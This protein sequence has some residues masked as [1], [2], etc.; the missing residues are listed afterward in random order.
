M[1]HSIE[2]SVADTCLHTGTKSISIAL[3]DATNMQVQ[4][5][6]KHSYSGDCFSQA[7]FLAR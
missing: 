6:V 4:Q 7:D 1:Q 5:Q 2:L 3:E